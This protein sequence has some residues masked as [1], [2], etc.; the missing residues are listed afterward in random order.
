MVALDIDSPHSLVRSLLQSGAD[1]H[2]I[3][4]D[5]NTALHFAIKNQNVQAIEWLVAENVNPETSSKN[6]MPALEYL[7][8]DCNI[9][10]TATR[11]RGVTDILT[12][13]WIIQMLAVTGTNHVGNS[14]VVKQTQAQLV[15]SL[16]S[17]LPES[18]NLSNDPGSLKKGG[19]LR[20]I[21]DIVHAL[22]DMFS[23]PLSLK[24]LCRVQIRRSLGRE[25]RRKLHQLNVPLP[26]QAYL[27]I[28]EPIPISEQ[29]QSPDDD[30]TPKTTYIN[31]PA[32]AAVGDGSWWTRGGDHKANFPRSVV[33]TIFQRC[34]NTR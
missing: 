17:F 25:F 19:Y 14:F 28:Y 30:P 18:L 12:S 3:D 26:L 21:H 34:Q 5:G 32:T 16:N 29:F 9:A 23:N 33:F 1:P 22:V 27:M 20:E 7:L 2:L 6:S 10:L 15:V 13:L 8:H 11:T 24:H 4:E 31:D